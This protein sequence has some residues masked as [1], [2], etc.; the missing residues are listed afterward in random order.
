MINLNSSDIAVILIHEIYGINKHV[1]D[2]FEHFEELGFDVICP[3]L[4]NLDE[5]F[6][7]E[8]EAKAYEYFMKNIGFD[9]A[10]EKV[11]D[12]ILEAK[13][14]YKKVYLVGSSIGATIAWLCSC[15]D[16]IC[17]GL[18]GYYGSR[19]RDY[20]DITPKCQTLLIFA[21]E[22]QSFN[23]KELA[24]KLENKVNI[25]VHVVDGAHGYNDS[26]S[27]KYNEQSA[28]E[29]EKITEDFLRKL[30]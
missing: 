22:E 19:I 27:K 9:S 16:N 11:K 21:E 14:R 25:D 2:M 7:Y 17:D 1:I 13:H 3:D 18:I 4:L 10:V 8:Q 26:F 23:P 30:Q 24:D 28:K 29:T 15:E 5:S 6:D 12:V 20:I